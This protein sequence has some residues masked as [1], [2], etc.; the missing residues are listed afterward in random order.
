[1]IYKKIGV[2]FI[3]FFAICVAIP[4]LH[5]QQEITQLQCEGPVPED[6]KKPMSEFVQGKSEFENNSLLGVFQLLSSGNVLY[7]NAEHDLLKKV[8]AHILEKNHLSSNIH[9]YLLRSG[10]FNAFATDDGYVFATTA[11]LAHVQSEDE[12]AFVLCHEISHYLLK[13]NLQSQVFKE[14]TVKDAWQ[15]VKKAR[16]NKK[17]SISKRDLEQSLDK[18]LRNY[19]AYNRSQESQADS[20]GLV[21]FLNTSYSSAVLENLFVQMGEPFPLFARYN[22]L[23]ELFFDQNLSAAR[24]I[25]KP[26]NYNRNIK[27]VDQTLDSSEETISDS[28]YSTHPDHLLRYRQLRMG[29]ASSK[30]NLERILTPLTKEMQLRL[31]SEQYLLHLQL[32]NYEHA[33]VF[34][35][36]LEQEFPKIQDLAAWKVVTGI[37]LLYRYGQSHNSYPHSAETDAHAQLG[38]ILSALPWNTLRNGIAIFMNKEVKDVQLFRIRDHYSHILGNLKNQY[39][40]EGDNNNKATF[41]WK[42]SAMAEINFV[43]ESSTESIV[44]RLGSF[45]P[46]IRPMAVYNS[47]PLTKRVPR[48]KAGNNDYLLLHGNMRYA[49]HRPASPLEIAKTSENG[50]AFM[51]QEVEKYGKKEGNNFQ[52]VDITDRARLSTENYNMMHQVNALVSELFNLDDSLLRPAG[53]VLMQKMR[54][55]GMPSKV[56]ILYENCYEGSSGGAGMWLLNTY[57]THFSFLLAT[58]LGAYFENIGTRYNLVNLVVDIEDCKADYIALYDYHFKFKQDAISALAQRLNKDLRRY[59]P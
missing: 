33:A 13:H 7:G 8:G 58:D 18:L 42:D 23:P 32:G 6:L 50:V 45:I 17:Q 52:R 28:I 21:M 54:R 5:G 27:I 9:F 3:C 56:N 41:N 12:L 11:L 36:I 22:Y 24:F 51:L 19:Y 39:V 55:D 26:E 44:M 43:N 38:R 10:L 16:K 34:L 15:E 48:E 31:W 37:P 59:H 4:V 47:K 30:S 57:V 40:A 46:A 2:P 25:S 53:A 20:L 14:K 29:I 1:M 49:Q 35:N